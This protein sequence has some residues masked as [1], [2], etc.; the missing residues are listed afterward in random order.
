MALPAKVA[1][2]SAAL[3]L[4]VAGTMLL[5]PRDASG[6]VAAVVLRLVADRDD[7]DANGLVDATEPQ[8]S[9][10]ARVDLV[11]APVSLLGGSLSFSAG[12]DLL[13][14]VDGGKLG[15]PLPSGASLIDGTTPIVVGP[16]T[17]FQGVR[18]GRALG[19]LKR[20][21]KSTPVV[22]D[23]VHVGFRDGAARVLELGRDRATLARTPPSRLEGGPESTFD[24]PDALRLFVAQPE[25][26]SPPGPL[27]VD[28][29][30]ATGLRLDSSQGV[31][32]LPVACPGTM[33]RELR[34]FSSVPL[35]F[36][37]DE[38][39]RRHPLI[40]G[41]SL[42]A[43]IGGALLLS[44]D[45]K[46]LQAIRVAGPFLP[47]GRA[48]RLKLRVRPFVLRTSAGGAPAVGG[49]E[50]GAIALLR[51]ELG[52][53]SGVWGQCGLSMGPSATFDVRV[54]NPPTSHLVAFGNDTGLPSSGGEARFLV[55]GRPLVFSIPPGIPPAA[56]AGL[57]ARALERVGYQGITSTNAR[58]GPG[59][60]P[61]ADVSVRRSDGSLGT[62]ELPKPA[63][64]LT[65]RV[66]V[67]R[68][69][70]SD[71]L[72]HFTDVDSPA[73]TLEERTL[74]KA[75]DDGD[76]RTIEVVVVDSFRGGGRIGESFIFGDGGSLRNVV[77][78]DRAGLRARKSSLALA[79]E[80]GHVLLD[81]PG[82]PD[83][84][85]VDTPTQ[86]MDSDASDASPFGPRRL[87]LS[88]CERVMRAAGPKART[89]LLEP[90]PLG[91][92][93]YDALLADLP[94]PTSR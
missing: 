5:P 44:Q 1:V 42:R 23:V 87:L 31:P 80:L 24:D 85:G 86:L 65:L 77:V 45:K 18:A 22:V 29:V 17:A 46:K 61:S 11:R 73:G 84:Y 7:D 47:G 41:R 64:D 43:E 10:D 79:H 89:P 32:L 3:A 15:P 28:S 50:Q 37:F 54:I 55:D 34:C 57:F 82:H 67:G 52:V 19:I 63:T 94:S 25:S 27:R 16:Q 21:D 39:D 38:L 70:L 78:V 14:V 8:L 4:F 69:D 71:G 58:T 35:R 59:A 74:L 90:W 6:D 62:V 92:L 88:E 51:G 60:L 75:I 56:V 91:V 48:E 40:E 36:V 53:A 76:P 9:A 30:G 72:S 33:A 26:L 81:E 68:V 13:R 20:G 2:R 12:G 93:K 83:D 49:T 66:D